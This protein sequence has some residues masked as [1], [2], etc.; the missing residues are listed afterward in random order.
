MNRLSV[1]VGVLALSALGLFVWSTR[2]T[3]R[4]VEPSQREKVQDGDHS[5]GPTNDTAS[6]TSIAVPPIEERRIAESEFGLLT[7]RGR[8]AGSDTEQITGATITWTALSQVH[9]G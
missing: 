8:V 1:I 7:L 3:L 5:I 2:G 4:P 9:F 6:L